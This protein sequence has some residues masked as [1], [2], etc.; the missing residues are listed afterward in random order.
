M[1]APLTQISDIRH[2]RDMWDAALS[3]TYPFQAIEPTA[4]ALI[5]MRR[6]YKIRDKTVSIAGHIGILTDAESLT[7][8]HASPATGRVEE[9][10]LR[11]TQSLLGG[12][13]V[14]L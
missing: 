3:A 7:F 1:D 12:I 8:I 2:V 6:N 14:E 11:T 9:R 10:P 13:A 5:V 4:G